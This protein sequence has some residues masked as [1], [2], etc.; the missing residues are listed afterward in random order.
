M[1]VIEIGS[2]FAWK[3]LL[4]RGLLR[5]WLANKHKQF[6]DFLNTLGIKLGSTIKHEA[7]E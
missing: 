1:K 5:Q 3:R 2:Y 6:H 4:K 7:W